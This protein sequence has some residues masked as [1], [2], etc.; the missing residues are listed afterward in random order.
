MATSITAVAIR[1]RSPLCSVRHAFETVGHDM[2]RDW[3]DR[4]WKFD[5]EGELYPEVLERLRGTPARLEEFV[6]QVPERVLVQRMDYEWTI[7]EN[8]G[9][10]GDLDGLFEGRV[11]DYLEDRKELRPADMA[12]EKTNN[13]RYNNQSITDVLAYARESR[14]SLVSTLEALAESDFSRSSYHARLDRQ[15]RL[16]DQCVFQATHDDYH[17]SV[18]RR[19][20]RSAAVNV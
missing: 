8:V 20:L 10:L 2:V 13:A 1:I 9:H 6:R 7:Q 11:E 19:L 14:A 15:M 3:I 17:L 12:N 5:T 4:T 18:M 16:I